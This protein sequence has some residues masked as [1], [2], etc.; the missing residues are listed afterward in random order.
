[1]FNASLLSTS[2]G[3]NP[4]IGTTCV[5]HN[6]KCA[7]PIAQSNICCVLDVLVVV[8]PEITTEFTLL[9]Q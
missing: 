9:L 7:E 4:K 2:V 3:I 8:H 1:M 6:L 5:Q